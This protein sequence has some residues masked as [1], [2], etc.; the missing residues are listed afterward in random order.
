MPELRRQKLASGVVQV[1]RNK[2]QTL[3]QINNYN[4]TNN[5]T[6]SIKLLSSQKNFIYYAYFHAIIIDKITLQSDQIFVTYYV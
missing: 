1:M 2:C 6:K 5:E 3:F 4:F